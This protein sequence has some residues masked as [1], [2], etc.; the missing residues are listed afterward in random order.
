V[1]PIL[2]PMTMRGARASGSRSSTSIG[3]SMSDVPFSDSP[4]PSAWVSLPG[5]LQSS[6]CR[7][8]RRRCRISSTP[9]TGSSA[10]IRTAAP[11]PSS[12]ATAFSSEWIP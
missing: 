10:R 3:P 4:I 2:S 9:S 6:S 1:I 7:A 8:T 12:S 11:T 5:P